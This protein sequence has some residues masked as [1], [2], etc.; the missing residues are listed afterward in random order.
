MTLWQTLDTY[1]TFTCTGQTDDFAAMSMDLGE[2]DIQSDEEAMTTDFTETVAEPA[3]R[4]AAPITE[5]EIKDLR[6][7]QE[8]KNTKAN[9]RWAA[10]VWRKWRD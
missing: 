2:F 6:E 9:T 8:S 5:S 10:G 1:N 4:F 7:D 3:H